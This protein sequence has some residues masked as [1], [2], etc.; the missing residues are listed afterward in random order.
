M[1]KLQVEPMPVTPAAHM[2]SGR[3]LD[4]TL[5]IWLLA[6]GLGK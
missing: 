5:S 1:V 3:V 2:G 6:S 4:A